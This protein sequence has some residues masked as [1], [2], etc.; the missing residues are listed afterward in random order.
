LATARQIEIYKLH[1]ECCIANGHPQA[2][3]FH[4]H[5]EGTE[6]PVG[7]QGLNTEYTFPDPRTTDH[8]MDAAV[9]V[10]A[11]WDGLNLRGVAQDG[12]DTTSGRMWME[13]TLVQFPA[14]DDSFNLV[15]V[16][17]DDLILD[18]TGVRYKLENPVLSADGSYWKAVTM[19]ER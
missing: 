16:Q 7:P 5:S 19:V 18:P 2:V 14:I 3:F 8:P 17:D 11:T 1:R 13:R 10:W 15:T 4:R 12:G 9:N 6:L